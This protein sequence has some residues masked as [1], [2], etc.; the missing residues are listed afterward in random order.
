MYQ[1]EQIDRPVHLQIFKP[2]GSEMKEKRDEWKNLR[3]SDVR[4]IVEAMEKEEVCQIKANIK[5]VDCNKEDATFTFLNVKGATLS[6][7]FR[8][9]QFMDKLEKCITDDVD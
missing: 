7:P 4:K 8:A 3:T 1:I 6:A 9:D 5:P 2:D